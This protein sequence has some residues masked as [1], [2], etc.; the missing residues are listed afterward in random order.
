MEV[1]LTPDQQA[2]V[3]DAVRSGRIQREEDA[4]TEA[5]AL[6]EQRERMRAEILLKVSEADASLHKGDGRSLDRDSLDELAE[7]VKM[8]GRERLKSLHMP[9]R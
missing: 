3:A 5:L 7:Q 2:F 8:R 9:G 1:T 6:W 4:V